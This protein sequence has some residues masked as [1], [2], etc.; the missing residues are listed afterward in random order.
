MYTG[1]EK[2]AS[3]AQRR[4]IAL[5]STHQAKH[6]LPATKQSI[7]QSLNRLSDNHTRQK[8]WEELVRFAERCDS[9][10]LPG[11]LQC[12]HSTT[13]QHTIACRRGAV[14]MYGHLAH[15]HPQ[16]V[17]AHVPKISDSIVAR[18]KEK[19]SLIHI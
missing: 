13:A 19:L 15:L 14:K 8:A 12:L 10:S 16:L 5:R 11:F 17:Q 9:H 1:S 4:V 2:L 3:P 6:M 7:L 18:L